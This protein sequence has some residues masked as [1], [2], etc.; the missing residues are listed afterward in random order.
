MKLEVGMKLG[1]LEL[2]ER[3][4]KGTKW[5]Y[6]C[7]CECGNV[8][9]IRSDSLTSK[10]KP[11][12]SCGCLAKDNYFKAK[13]IANKRFGR[14]VALEPTDDRDKWNGSIIWK[15]KCDCGNIINVCSGSLKTGS[16]VSC[17][18]YRKEYETRQGSNI[19]AIHVRKNIKED[20]NLQV[21][22]RRDTLKLNNTSGVTGV[23]WDK[24]RNKWVAQIVFQGKHIYLGRY[25]N[26]ED[27]IAA[28]EEAEEKYFKPILDKYN[29]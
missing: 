12:R 7:K 17:G 6:I 15:C 20:T 26:K 21:I 25:I 10:T 1:K 16:I 29:R 14:L 24:S 28:R 18:C 19:G 8:K 27:A 23:I 5:G 11:A 9:W 4:K 22:S 3:T 13:D 2:L